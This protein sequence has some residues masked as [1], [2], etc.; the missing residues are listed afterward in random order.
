MKNKS[1]VLF[2]FFLVSCTSNTIFEEPKDLIPKDTM[3]ALIIDMI[4]A[5]SAKYSKNLNNEKKTN[6]MPF[7]YE[8]YNI[9]SLRFSSSNFYYVSE[10][11]QYQKMMEEVKITLE[12]EK[13]KYA[14]IKNLQDSIRRDSIKNAPIINDRLLKKPLKKIPE[15]NLKF[16]ERN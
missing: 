2:L 16:M 3:K 5:G 7:I 9:D 8:K 4:V 11:N 1:L 15:E 6:Y 13:K 12:M 14:D 10:I